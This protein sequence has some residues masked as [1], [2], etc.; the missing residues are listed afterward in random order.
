MNHYRHPRLRTNVPAHVPSPPGGSLKRELGDGGL[1]HAPHARTRSIDSAIPKSCGLEAATRYVALATI[2]LSLAASSWA[3]P[4]A[5][6]PITPLDEFFVFNHAGIPE[7]PADWRLEIAGAVATPLSLDLDAVKQ[8]GSVTEMATLECAWSRG[9]F[10]WVGNA[11]WTGVP[12][13]TLL[14]QAGP[15][16][17]AAS[18]AIEAEDE[19]VLG[20]IAIESILARDDFVLAW[21]MNGEELPPEQGYPLRLVVP[22]AG[23]FHWVQWVTHIEVKASPASWSFEDFPPHARISSVEDFD[24]LPLGTHVIEGMVMAGQGVEIIQ[25]EFSDD[26]ESWRVAELLTEFVPNVWRRWRITWDG[27]QLGHNIL[28]ARVTDATGAVQNENGGYSWRGF[29]V[30]VTGDTDGD[31]DGIADTVDNCPTV[32]NPDQRDSDNN[33]IGDPCD[34]NC[35]DRD[36]VPPVNFLDFALLAQAWRTA[37]DANDLY[38]LAQYWVSPCAPIIAPAPEPSP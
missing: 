22:G 4:L 13:K 3:Q 1:A 32:Y 25:V 2:L 28:Y 29:A 17:E 6:P 19:Y 33:G 20:D 30:A 23:G 27:I 18:V 8:Y 31:A 36:G 5:P 26:G 21:Q 10:L 37:T 35:P 11:T 7:I 24:V 15:L 34:P 9:P 14:E 16:P 12:L 38:R